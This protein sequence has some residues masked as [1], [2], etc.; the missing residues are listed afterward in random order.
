[1]SMLQCVLQCVLQFVLQCDAISKAPYAE[2]YKLAHLSY[3][4]GSKYGI[5]VDVC[6]CLFLFGGVLGGGGMCAC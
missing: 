2:N 1:M 4:S 3:G 5:Y 6:V